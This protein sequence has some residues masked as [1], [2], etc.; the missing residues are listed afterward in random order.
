PAVLRIGGR[1]V[2]TDPDGW[3]LWR[4]THDGLPRCAA[5]D[6]LGPGWVG[7]VGFGAAELL[8]PRIASASR[9]APQA[10]RA[11]GL[12][13]PLMRLA[14]FDRVIVLDA[15]TRCAR[16][17]S[18]DTLRE[19][20][21]LTTRP[22]EPDAERWN[23][24]CAAPAPP[25]PGLHGVE[26]TAG[27][28][29][30]EHERIV[31]RALDYVSAGDIYQVNLSRR[32]R[33]SGVGCPWELYERVRRANPAP[34]G[35]LLAWPATPEAGASPNW[36]ET[37]RLVR[38][39]ASV[40]PELFLRVRG[41]EVLTRPIKGT[42][43]RH[44][45]AA[46]DRGELSDLLG[47]AKDSAEL[48]M[49]VDLHRN[50]LGRVCRPGSVEVTDARRVEAHARVFHTLA[51]VRG[52]LADGA[53]ALAALAACFPAGSIS[54]VP[55][56]RACQIIREL[57]PA[58]RGVFTGAIGALGL[59]GQLTMSVAIRTLQI[60]DGAADLHVGGG[61]VAE[62]DPRAEFEETQAKARGIL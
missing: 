26:V 46:L 52:R 1:I 34:Y 43:P 9:S 27:H 31:R 6:G 62:S 25:M 15:A 22:I 28:D 55:K 16:L 38:A 59:D 37:P 20:L 60:A 53:D 54:G 44:L 3:R 19:R 57:E 41:A 58:P 40:S 42:R 50:D 13:L 14:L 49:I 24:A 8:E 10:R 2:D 47:S 30:D 5:L 21:G 18:A 23:A 11:D 39:V 45:D 7:F 17:L 61:I 33:L 29:R 51:E 36:R 12:G 4:R 32:L 56:I 48:A 35:G